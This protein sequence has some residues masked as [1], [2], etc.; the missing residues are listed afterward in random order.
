MLK[1]ILAVIIVAIT[2]SG[3]NGNYSELSP[4]QLHELVGGI[5][6]SGS[7]MWRGT[8]YCGSDEQYDYFRHQRAMATDISVK[9]KKG[10][11]QLPRTIAFPAKKSDWIDVSQLLK[12]EGKPSS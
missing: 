10:G 3:C 1:R 9:V 12:S 7:D 4:H 2:L 5:Q 8:F 11:I 6:G